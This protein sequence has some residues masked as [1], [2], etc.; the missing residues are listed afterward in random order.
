[1]R[2]GRPED[3]A[4]R[5]ERYRAALL[6][7]ELTG[8]SG[9]APRKIVD[10]SRLTPIGRVLRRH[11]ID[12]LPQLWNVLRGEMTLVGP[13]PCLPYEYELQAPWHRLRYR[14]KPG[15]TG[16]W[17]AHGRSRVSFDE[18]AYMDYCYGRARSFVLDLRLILR[19]VAVVVTGEGGK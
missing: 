4:L 10:E 14:V 5:R 3:D 17:Q 19:T 15:L 16:P 18:M 11:S 1:M 9:P 8:A 13:R 6:D 7:Q 12:E 2:P